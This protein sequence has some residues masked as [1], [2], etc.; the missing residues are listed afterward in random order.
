MVDAADPRSAAQLAEAKRVT[1]LERKRAIEMERERLAQEATQRPIQATIFNARPPPA[2][3]APTAKHRNKGKT[4]RKRVAA[5]SHSAALVPVT[6][7]R[8]AAP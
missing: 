4:K 3:S 2:T 1:A 5:A 8:R 6:A 7:Q